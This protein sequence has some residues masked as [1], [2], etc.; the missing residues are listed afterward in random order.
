MR[1]IDLPLVQNEL[2]EL[3]KS[4]KKM[5]EPV[6]GYGQAM[7]AA[8]KV[9]REMIAKALK[10]KRASPAEMIKLLAPTEEAL[11]KLE[12]LKA[13]GCEEQREFSNHLQMLCGACSALGWVTTADPKGYVGDA[14]NAVP[15]FARKI[16]AGYRSEPQEPE[17]QA[18]EGAGAVLVHEDASLGDG[19]TKSLKGLMRALRDYVATHH[20]SGLTWAPEPK[21]AAPASGAGGSLR[22]LPTPAPSSARCRARLLLMRVRGASEGNTASR[23]PRSHLLFPHVLRLRFSAAAGA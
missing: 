22:S 18:S 23:V 21:K 10:M 20:S 2:E 19:L 11:T 3:L 12:T 6:A 13:S 9:Q 16:E 14:L 8:F 17:E 5:G 7:T 15:V 1:E 4:C